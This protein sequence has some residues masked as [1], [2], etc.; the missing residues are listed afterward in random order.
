MLDDVLPQLPGGLEELV[1]DLTVG[2]ALEPFPDERGQAI[3]AVRVVEALQ[4]EEGVPAVALGDPR[5][6]PAHV[7]LERVDDISEMHPGEPAT[8]VGMLREHQPDRQAVPCRGG[9]EAGEPGEGVGV[10]EAH[11]G[12]VDHGHAEVDVEGEDGV[13]MQR[14]HSGRPVDRYEREYRSSRNARPEPDDIC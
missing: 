12:K 13:E 3:A 4:L 6:A 9:D 8:D 14:V 11:P 1:H 2:A 7:D 5:E 10:D